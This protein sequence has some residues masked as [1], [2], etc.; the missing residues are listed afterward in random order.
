MTEEEKL[1]VLASKIEQ[2][3]DVDELAHAFVDWLALCPEAEGLIN[4]L[5]RCTVRNS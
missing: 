3:T 5:R 2:I 4:A 1:L